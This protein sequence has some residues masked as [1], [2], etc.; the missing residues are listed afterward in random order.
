M[1]FIAPPFGNYLK[2]QDAI[3]V[4]GS[5]TFQPR[6]GLWKQVLKTLRPTA[7]G[8]RNK[9]GLRNKGIEHGLT[10]TKFNEVLSLAAISEWD[11]INLESAIS[12]FRNVEINIGCPNVDEEINIHRHPSSLKGFDLFPNDKRKWCIVKVPP[13]IAQPEIDWIVECG[14]KQIHCSNT[15]P[16]D[17]GGLSGRVLVPHTLR[18]IEYI[19]STH[20][21]VE[22]IAGGGVTQDWHAQYYLDA[23]ADHISLGTV[24]FRPW[25]VKKIINTLINQD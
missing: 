14:Y 18:I 19:K 10:V 1:F 23:G 12:P 21:H 20:K 7:N 25:K 11:W 4:T 24:C 5:W 8:W 17:K 22:V 16:S 9:I 15:L 13:T 2:F 3:S 6:P